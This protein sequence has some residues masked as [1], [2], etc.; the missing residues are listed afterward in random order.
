ML[1]KDPKNTIKT[2]IIN[3]STIFINCNVDII[4]ISTNL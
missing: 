4:H 2:L 1:Y 3:G